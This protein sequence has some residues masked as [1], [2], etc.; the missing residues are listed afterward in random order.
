MFKINVKMHSIRGSRPDSCSSVSGK[1]LIVSARRRG[2]ELRAGRMINSDIQRPCRLWV[3]Q[4]LNIN[5][6]FDGDVS[7]QL[8]SSYM[9]E[10][11]SETR[12][13]GLGFWWVEMFGLCFF[14]LLLKVSAGWFLAEQT[15][16]WRTS[17]C[18][19]A[20][21][22]CEALYFSSVCSF[23][24]TFNPSLCVC[25]NETFMRSGC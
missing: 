10:Y 6:C 21:N 11:S 23:T 9:H 24:L 2:S 8:I 18:N 15:E 19:R 7:D 25:V 5:R 13:S 20:E 22:A 12:A 4:K 16:A 3:E 14:V 1:R 17:C